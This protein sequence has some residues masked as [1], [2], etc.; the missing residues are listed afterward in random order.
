[1]GV[2]ERFAISA[3]LLV[4]S[5]VITKI[6]PALLLTFALLIALKAQY[7]S[8][9]AIFFFLRIPVFFAILGLL[10]IVLV[11][12]TDQ[13]DTLWVLSKRYFPLSITIE[14]L[15]KARIVLFRS[16]NSLLAL[17]VFVTATSIKEKSI[18]AGKLHIP[19]PL[20]E[21]GVLSFRYMQ[22]LDKK[23]RE[24]KVAQRLRLGY[25]SYR[26]SFR[27]LSLLLSTVFFYSVTIFRLNHQALLARG[28]TGVLHYG[29]TAASPRDRA[30]FVGVVVGAVALLLYL[31]T[32]YC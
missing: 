5:L 18:L 30:W 3:G 17:C 31:Y 2:V 22:L 26:Q 23:Q 12:S 29:D 15:E 27:S 16:L 6:L 10:S 21:L 11:L 9:Q 13:A 4:L 32:K 25:R 7:I 19:Q 20:V 24:I 28:Y 1:M 8:W 14:S